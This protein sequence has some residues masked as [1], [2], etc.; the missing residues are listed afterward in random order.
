MTTAPHTAGNEARAKRSAASVIAAANVRAEAARRNLHSKDLAPYLGLKPGQVYRKMRGE[1]LFT[2][3]ELEILATEVFKM[4]GSW[5]LLRDH[6][7]GALLAI[8]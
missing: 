5:E 4:A 6:S 1:V 3:D 2:V 7:N 8:A